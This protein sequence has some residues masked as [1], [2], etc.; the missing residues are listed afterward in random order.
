MSDVVQ[1]AIDAKFVLYVAGGAFT[2]I[3]ALLVILAK[4]IVGG[5]NKTITNCHNALS[6]KHEEFE[7][8]VTNLE[9]VVFRRGD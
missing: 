1:V 2:I 8:R 3:A 4:V 9:S 6:Q 7:R 5:I